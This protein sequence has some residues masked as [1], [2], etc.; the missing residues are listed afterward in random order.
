MK[1]RDEGAGGGRERE[2]MTVLSRGSGRRVG[3]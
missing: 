2:K 3:G 1:E